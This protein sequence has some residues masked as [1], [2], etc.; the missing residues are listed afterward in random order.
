MNIFLQLS[1]S[2]AAFSSSA[3]SDSCPPWLI[4]LA[5]VIFIYI[6]NKD[7]QNKKASSTRRSTKYKSSRNIRSPNNSTVYSRKNI[8]YI[9]FHEDYANYPSTIRYHN[10]KGIST[11]EELNSILDKEIDEEASSQQVDPFFLDVTS[12]PHQATNKRSSIDT[13][14]IL[15]TNWADF[16]KLIH[17]NNIQ[18][19]YHFTDKRNI[20]SIYNSGGLFSWNDCKARGIHVDSPGSNSISRDIDKYKQLNQYVHLS[21]NPNQPMLYIA[22]SEGRIKEAIILKI[23]TSLI[24]WESTLFSDRNAASTTARIG[25]SIDF[26]KN[27]NFS[28]ACGSTWS[29]NEKGLFQAEVLVKSHVPLKYI[30]F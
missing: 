26:F 15:K 18:Y 17:M 30:Y 7:D 9:R 16:N 24:L 10:D 22:K 20:P 23:D 13:D 19:L 3:E 11:K 2:A 12:H 1:I 6:A 14:I 4:V 5:I 21:F 29:E 28:I 27:I 8:D 25:G